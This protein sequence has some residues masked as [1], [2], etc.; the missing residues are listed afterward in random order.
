MD[1]FS[2]KKHAAPVLNHFVIL[3]PPSSQNRLLA[4]FIEKQLDVR[5][6]VC[7]WADCL[8]IKTAN[9]QQILILIDMG[10]IPAEGVQQQLL[11][12]HNIVAS[13]AL[14]NADP[15]LH[16]D[17]VARWPKVRGVFYR[18][19]D[20]QQL[21]KG[22]RA[23]RD[24]EYWLPRKILTESL[25]RSRSRHAPTLDECCTLTRREKEILL[26][27]GSGA[28]NTEIARQLNLSPHTI[29]T[30]IYNLFKKIEVSNRVQA[31]SWARTH[32]DTAIHA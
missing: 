9:T 31:V 7:A 25:E 4:G 19:T 13:I 16:D 6:T 23:L 12:F 8:P 3:A 14:L 21:I 1:G 2:P 30:H 11:R 29:K 17:W 26:A 27:M 20:E 24:N 18:D 10:A 32:L 28:C 15:A 22:L 5:C